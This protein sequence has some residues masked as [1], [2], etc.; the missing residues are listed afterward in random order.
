A[1]F[2]PLSMAS[3]NNLF[4]S[5]V[6]RTAHVVPSVN[7]RAQFLLKRS[8]HVEDSRRARSEQPFVRI[9]RK[10]INLL[11]TRGKGAESL[12]PI[13]TKENVSLAQASANFV[14]VDAMPRNEMTG[15]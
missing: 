5:D 10:K 1:G 13:H 11:D 12:N 3:K 6:I 9:C 7:R 15:S 4:L 8:S 2:I 14:Q